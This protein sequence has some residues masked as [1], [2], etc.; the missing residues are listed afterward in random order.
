MP[1]PGYVK[2]GLHQLNQAQQE[3]LPW[4]DPGAPELTRR[5]DSRSRLLVWVVICVIVIHLADPLH[6]QLRSR[7][8]LRP[9][10]SDRMNVLPLTPPRSGPFVKQGT[11]IPRMGLG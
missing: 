7:G 10:E 11:A 8:W 2:L 5:T 3:C 6:E 1:G 4:V 9:M